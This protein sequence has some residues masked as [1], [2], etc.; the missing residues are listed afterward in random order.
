MS[1][2]IWGKYKSTKRCENLNNVS[3]YLCPY[4]LDIKLYKIYSQQ[5]FCGPKA[6]VTWLKEF[7]KQNFQTDPSGEYLIQ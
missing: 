4:K 1:I 2:N 6:P 3:T 5:V 7:E